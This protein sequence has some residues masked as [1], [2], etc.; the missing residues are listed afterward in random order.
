MATKR[1][2]VIIA[3]A[4]FVLGALVLV[5][6]ATQLAPQAGQSSAGS[7]VGGPF[8]LQD[9][10]GATVTDESL[11]GQPFVVFFGFTHCPDICPT[12][13][14]ELSEALN[15]LGDDAEKISVLFVS[16][17][18]ERD[19]PDI[20]AR[21]I[22]SFN[23]RIRALTGSPEAI[24]GMVKAYRGYYRKVPT[25]GGDYTMD[26]TA[27]VYLMDSEGDFVAPLNMERPAE[28]VAADIQRQL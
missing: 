8:S 17:D 26:H 11:R 6:A 23:P 9:Q 20:L 3:A 28:E 14:F 2:N 19:T 18:P 5:Y 13:L 4:L 12:K 16:V 15:A 21:Y 10:T 1:I 7:S 24:D 22:S 25:E 27:V